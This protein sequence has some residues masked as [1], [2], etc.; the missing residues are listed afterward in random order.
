MMLPTFGIAAIDIKPI[1]DDAHYSPLV[2][3]TDGV[4]DKMASHELLVV[5]IGTLFGIDGRQLGEAVLCADSEALDYS[6][7]HGEVGEGLEDVNIIHGF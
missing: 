2:I 1:C 7:R 3:I 4:L 6:S 5:P